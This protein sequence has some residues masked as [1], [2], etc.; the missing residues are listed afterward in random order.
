M[1]GRVPPRPLTA[2]LVLAGLAGC[3][4]PAGFAAAPGPGRMT[5]SNYS[6]A[7]ADVEAVVTSNPDCTVRRGGGFVGESRFALPLNGTRFLAAP[8][9]AELCWRRVL[10]ATSATA[11]PRWSPWSRVYLMA[12][13]TIDVTL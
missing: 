1:S 11:A 10:P 12:G 8:A 6:L 4:L 13:R 9:G 3:A 5:L 7:R 2:V